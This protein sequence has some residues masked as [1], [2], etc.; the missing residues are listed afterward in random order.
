MFITG[1]YTREVTHFFWLH[2]P[3]LL[4]SLPFLN[5][6]YEFFILK[7]SLW[8]K[9][10]FPLLSS[11]GSLN[12]FWEKGLKR[13]GWKKSC[14]YLGIMYSKC[15][16]ICWHTS[17]PVLLQYFCF[18]SQRLFFFLES[19]VNRNLFLEGECVCVYRKA[20]AISVVEQRRRRVEE[21]ELK[22][23]WNQSIMY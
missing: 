18:L 22:V 14:L 8:I 11:V 21:K 10:F 2:A 4:K 12:A 13:G 3:L 23:L 19:E 5:G 20:E 15:F 9:L 7:Y 16:S 1:H 17:W 6:C